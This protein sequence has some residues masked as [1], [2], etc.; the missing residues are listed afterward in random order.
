MILKPLVL[1]LLLRLLISTDK[2]FLCSGVYAGSVFILGLAF[3]EPFL[4]VLLFSGIA[5]A[6]SSL[7]FWLLYRFDEGI[8][9]W[10]IMIGGLVIGLVWQK[11]S[12]MVVH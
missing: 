7:Y 11:V 9:W 1:V 4:G 5:F 3:R 6:L 8:L 10:I 2:P 12:N